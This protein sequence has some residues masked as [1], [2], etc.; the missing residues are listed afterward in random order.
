M[1]IHR[2]AC[3]LAFINLKSYL[4]LRRS[5]LGTLFMLVYIWQSAAGERIQ[6]SPHRREPHQ[7][8]S[9]ARFSGRSVA[10]PVR[11]RVFGR[12]ETRGV[13]LQQSRVVVRRSLRPPAAPSPARSTY[14]PCFSSPHTRSS[15]I[16]AER[17]RDIGLQVAIREG[18]R[19]M[20]QSQFLPVR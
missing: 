12:C 20:R 16:R 14:T 19:Q 4:P 18:N 15:K 7:R 6:L 17:L 10:R 5:S 2:D 13:C 11:R 3:L 8:T 1:S 9:A